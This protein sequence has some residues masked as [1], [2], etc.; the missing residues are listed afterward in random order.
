MEGT[1]KLTNTLLANQITGE[2][3][4]ALLSE[5][6]IKKILDFSYS[7]LENPII[8]F[9]HGA[10]MICFSSKTDINE[11]VPSAMSFDADG[12]DR[13]SF[14]A[15]LDKDFEALKHANTPIIVDDGYC[16]PGKRRIVVSL[17]F[18][19]SL[20]GSLALFEV[21]RPLTDSDSIFLKIISE[22]IT[23]KIASPGF[24]ENLYGLQVEQF[25]LDLL[26][27]HEINRN[28]NDWL[29]TINA[30]KHQRFRTAALDIQDCERRQ[31]EKL[32]LFISKNLSFALIIAYKHDL[33]VLANPIDK[34][35]D[36]KLKQ[37]LSSAVQ[38]FSIEVGVSNIFKAIRDLRCYY[39]QAVHTR[40]FGHKI[41]KESGLHE[42]ERLKF[43]I[44]LNKIP[45]DV[46]LAQ[47]LNHDLISLMENDK[48]EKTD[49]CN[50]LLTFAKCGKNRHKTCQT[51]NIHKNTLS[52][53]LERITEL[54]D[55]S[56]D[57]GNY[58]LDILLSSMIM[59]YM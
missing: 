35:D 43:D 28:D 10:K 31:T 45:P 2:L 53:R 15:A 11:Q 33:V 54:L 40:E 34:K 16:F 13:T 7:F 14:M 32:K 46:D 57:D 26:N 18:N 27:G 52:Y 37:I 41:K 24:Q 51:L 29:T 22:V 58:L 38:E 23:N 47:Y 19:S 1:G 50:T 3:L 25:M 49:Y 59:S 17:Y 48:Q 36:D 55:C 9:G 21:N 42:F 20:V 30:H 44:L 5:K 8:A 4:N 39:L 56:I 6:S 12:M